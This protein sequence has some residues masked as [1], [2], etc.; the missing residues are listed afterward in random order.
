M[1]AENKVPQ[2]PLILH[3]NRLMEAFSCSDDERDFYLEIQEGATLFL[4]LDK[5]QEHLDGFKKELKNTPNRYRIVPKATHF[6]IKKFMEGFV[7]EKVYDVDT[8]EKMLDIIHSK[9]AR[10]NFI[11]FLYD[12]LVELD[13]WQQYFQERSRVKVIE[14]L[15]N[16]D[17][18]FVFEEDMDL[19]KTLVEKVK[20]SIFQKKTAKDV[21]V[22]RQQLVAKSKTYYSSEALNPRPKR[23]RPPKQVAKVEVTLEYSIDYFFTLPEAL[24]GFIFEP[25][26]S[27]M[28][29]LSFFES[30]E[31]SESL[32]DRLKDNKTSTINPLEAFSKKLESLKALSNQL[33]QTQKKSPT[34]APDET[35]ETFSESDL[36]KRRGRPKKMP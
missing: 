5:T 29:S 33:V 18:I 16:N 10:E 34:S 15:R 23:G 30:S 6:E 31:N 12:H 1:K 13:K 11:A 24:R 19:S 9:D 25:E 28:S 8:K 17:I 3:Y 2:C 35:S 20:K 32:L 27:S 7:N 22:A 26:I 14:W 4:D 21:Q 36:P